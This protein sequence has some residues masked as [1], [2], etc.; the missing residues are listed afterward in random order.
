MTSIIHGAPAPTGEGATP[1][2]A[3]RTLAPG[4][5]AA[6]RVTVALIVMQAVASAAGLLVPGLYQD[7]IWAASTMRGG[8][9]VSLAVGVPLFTI[10]LLMAARG[11]Y[12]GQL[13]WIGMLAYTLYNSAYYALGAAFNDIFLLHVGLLVLS[14][15]TLV[16]GLANL[17]VTGIAARFSPRTPARLAGAFL[18]LVAAGMGGMWIWSS[19]GFALTGEIATGAIPLAAVHLVYVLDLTLLVP[20]LAIGGLLLWR[21]S[22]WGWVAGTA[23]SVLGAVYLL[24][25]FVSGVFQARAGV[26]GVQP[27]AW[28]VLVLGAIFAATAVALLRGLRPDGAPG[29][30]MERSGQ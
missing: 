16:L 22:A 30:R 2:V 28:N 8:D 12:R 21:R 17:D 9:L 27:V 4:L 20:G 1:G 10:A 11:S 3:R 18:L 15:V 5:V 7:E 23:M 29:H 24:N 14:I 19:I 26:P 25:L 6:Y 13:V